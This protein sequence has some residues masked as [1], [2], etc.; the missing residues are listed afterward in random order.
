M[1]ALL[2]AAGFGSR[3]QPFTFST[4]KCLVNV[5]GRPLLSYWLEILSCAEIKNI[6]IN[7][8]WLANEVEKFISSNKWKKNI[9]LL[10]ED[11]LLGS[12][13]TILQNIELFEGQELFVAHA[14]N[15]IWFDIDQFFASHFDRP[16]QTS[17]TMLCF[18]SSHPEKVGI[19][20]RDELGIVRKFREK[21][22]TKK[23]GC[24]AN[25]AVYILSQEALQTIKL[26]HKN[27]VD[28]STDVLSKFD[29][30]IFGVDISGYLRDVGSPAD[31][32]EARV[33]FPKI[34]GRKI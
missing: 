25:G 21:P 34:Y 8:H 4:P 26:N 16:K 17:M 30:D 33:E 28:L 9:I 18:T 32:V 31:L 12:A 22:G 11:V 13:G 6:Y 1:N 29:G 24:V 27:A 7:T 2:L 15:L 3:L 14:D 23:F 5:N 20:T 19:V 10:H